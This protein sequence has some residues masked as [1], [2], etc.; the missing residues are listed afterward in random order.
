MEVTSDYT[1]VLYSK[2]N[3]RC[4]PAQAPV[5]GYRPHGLCLRLPA[6]PHWK[7][8]TARLRHGSQRASRPTVPPCHEM[9]RE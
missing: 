1:T 3:R 7:L 8:D 9:D 6:D 4:S 5:F 2:V